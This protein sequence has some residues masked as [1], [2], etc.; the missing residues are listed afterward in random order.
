MIYWIFG[1]RT[2]QDVDALVIVE[3]LGSIA[4][5]KQTV[6]DMESKLQIKYDRTLNLNLGT[7]ENGS[8]KEVYKGTVDEV[9]NSIMDTYSLHKQEC[10]LLITHR[11][12]RDVDLKIIRCLRIILSFYSRTPHRTQVK[13]ALSGDVSLKHETLKAIDISTVLELGSGKHVD[14]YDYLKTLAF[15]LGQTRALIDGVELYT[16]EDIGVKYPQLRIFLQRTLSDL[17]VLES[18]KQ[19]LLSQIDPKSLKY[20]Y[21]TFKK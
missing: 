1:S 9:N 11:I 12:H 3:K 21:E 18:F 4:E 8:L 7:L 19:D 10:P 6:S 5:N 15:Q 14:F 13:K 2:S 17:S 20:Q 16:K